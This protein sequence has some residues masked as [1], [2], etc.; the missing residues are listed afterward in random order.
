VTTSTLRRMVTKTLVAAFV[1]ALF[2]ALTIETANAKC[3]AAA[4]SA[5]TQDMVSAGAPAQ[6]PV[7]ERTSAAAIPV[8]KTI[9]IGSYKNVNAVRAA[10]DTAPCAIALGDWADEIMGRPGF[11]F[12]RKEAELDLAVVSVAEL[13]FGEQGGARRD[14]YARASAIGLELCPAETGPILRLA[15]LDQP[16]G[17]FLHI[18]MRPVAR[19]S[20]E[21]V[22]FMLG[23]GGAELILVGGDARPEVVLP[24]AVRLVF[25][26]PR[27]DAIGSSSP[28]ASDT[29]VKR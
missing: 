23:N 13:G 22:D 7:I 6:L 2:T 8:W 26:R 24:G 27:L 21:L 9:T 11:A 14:I 17:E 18:A 19:Y 29:L 16:P 15:Y 3:P 1:F 25:V 5:A 10:V 28:V 4:R 12:S 20:G